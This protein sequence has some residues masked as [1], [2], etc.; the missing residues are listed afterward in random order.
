MKMSFQA[1][2][3]YDPEYKGY[4]VEVP[5]LPGCLSQGRTI[6]EA[7]E[8]IRDA[9]RGVL[10]SMEKHGT[11]YTRPLKSGFVGEIAV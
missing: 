4:V 6:E 1:V 5:E 2:F 3:T 9:I 7:E 10:A 11:P 8:N